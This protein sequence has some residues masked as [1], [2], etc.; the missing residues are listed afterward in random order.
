MRISAE[1][2][3]WR[4]VEEAGKVQ[5]EAISNFRFQMALLRSS[6]FERLEERSLDCA[7][8]RENRK[9]AIFAGKSVGTL[10]SG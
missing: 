3:S 7:S 5:G 10:R 6:V 2:K 1:G 8:R 9:D 4:E